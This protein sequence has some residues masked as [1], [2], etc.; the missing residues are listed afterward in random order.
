MAAGLEVEHAVGVGGDQLDVLLVAADREAEVQVVELRGR[1]RRV[2]GRRQ[3]LGEMDAEG[4]GADVD[5]LAVGDRDDLAGLVHRPGRAGAEDHGRGRVGVGQREDAPE[6]RDR[7]AAVLRLGE[8]DGLLG[9][10]ERVAVGATE[11][12]DTAR[13]QHGRDAR[14]EPAAVDVDAVATVQVLDVPAGAGPAEDGVFAG[15]LGFVEADRAGPRAADEVAA[16]Q[17]PAEA[18]VGLSQPRHG[19]DHYAGTRTAPSMSDLPASPRARA[20]GACARA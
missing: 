18:A 7:L 13:G 10:D 16:A 4:P 20:R 17:Q 1:G 5:G 14:L 6:R 15:H 19:V 9:V 8:R 12:E 2:R 11:P 3:R